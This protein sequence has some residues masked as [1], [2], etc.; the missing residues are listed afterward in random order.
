MR[1]SRSR[2]KT[3]IRDESINECSS[4]LS[5]TGFLLRREACPFAPTTMGD[6]CSGAVS[7]SP[8][9]RCGD[10]Q[11]VEALAT[12]AFR[13]KE[14]VP[15]RVVLRHRSLPERSTPHHGCNG[16]LTPVID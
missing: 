9:E 1:E 16:D 5:P 2:Q 15:S 10:E 6:G 13:A 11:L 7:D 14:C 4:D 12:A 8:V 3:E